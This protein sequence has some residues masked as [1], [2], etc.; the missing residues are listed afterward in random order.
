MNQN[1]DNRFP[2]QDEPEKI[3]GTTDENKQK[4][5]YIRDSGKIEDLPSE[6]ELVTMK[7]EPKSADNTES[8]PLADR[9]GE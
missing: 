8:S 1:S 9:N 5:K 4:E 7:A 6:D 2:E 3:A